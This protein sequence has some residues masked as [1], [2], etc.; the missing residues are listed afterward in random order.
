MSEEKPNSEKNERKNQNIGELILDKIRLMLKK[1]IELSD[2]LRG[3]IDSPYKM[4]IEANTPIIN[5]KLHKEIKIPTFIS[6]AIANDNISVYAIEIDN[7]KILIK[8]NKE[9]GMKDFESVDLGYKTISVKEL[10]MLFYVLKNL[11]ENDIIE[12]STSIDNHINQIEN[13]KDLLIEL[14]KDNG[15]KI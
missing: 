1:D 4:P 12:I 11:S 9:N 8:Y 10:F 14:L 3:V 13:E 15:I 7:N 6:H 2:I 5:I